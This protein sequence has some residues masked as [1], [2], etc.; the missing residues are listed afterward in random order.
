MPQKNASFE[1][2]YTSVEYNASIAIGTLPDGILSP[3]YSRVKDLKATY[4][5]CCVIVSSL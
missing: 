5:L 1:F 3:Y 4:S 2:D